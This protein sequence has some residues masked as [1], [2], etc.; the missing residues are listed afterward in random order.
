M[1]ALYKHLL[2]VFLALYFTQIDYI[3]ADNNRDFYKI[4]GIKRSAKPRDIKKAF[5]KMSILHHP[6]KNP[7]DENALKKYQDVSAA[8]DML[9]DVE[10]RRKYDKC[11][12]ECA[13]KEDGGGW[14]PWGGMFG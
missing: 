7:G 9:N 2:F 13:N 5:K 6:D 8:Y 10:K 14:D 4:L 11:G 3:N 1:K 12:E